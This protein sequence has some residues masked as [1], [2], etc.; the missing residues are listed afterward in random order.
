MREAPEERPFLPSVYLIE[1]EIA[2]Q[3]KSF[4]SS[5]VD[6]HVRRYFKIA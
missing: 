2:G 4:E 6:A 1:G 5:R 3:G